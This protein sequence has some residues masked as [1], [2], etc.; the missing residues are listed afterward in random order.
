M[1]NDYSQTKFPQR[2]K[3]ESYKTYVKNL[4]KYM[5]YCK[6]KVEKLSK[7]IQKSYVFDA[8]VFEQLDEIIEDLFS[9]IKNNESLYLRNNNNVNNIYKDCLDIFMTAFY[10]YKTE[11]E[12]I[13][14]NVYNIK[15][16]FEQENKVNKICMEQYISIFS[17]FSTFKKYYDE[18]NKYN[19]LDKLFILNEMYNEMKQERK[20]YKDIKKKDEIKKVENVAINEG[21]EEQ[22][23]LGEFVNEIIDKNTEK[24]VISNEKINIDKLLKSDELIYKQFE[25]KAEEIRN[26]IENFE[27]TTRYAFEG[28]ERLVEVYCDNLIAV[29]SFYKCQYLKI[30]NGLGSR[31]DTKKINQN[32]IDKKKRE[33]DYIINKDVEAIKRNI[34]LKKSIM[35]KITALKEALLL[36]NEEQKK[37]LNIKEQERQGVLFDIKIDD[38]ETEKQVISNKKTYTQEEVD[39]MIKELNDKKEKEKEKT[40]EDLRRVYEDKIKSFYKDKDEE[41]VVKFKKLEQSIKSKE[42]ENEELKEKLKKQKELQE[43]FKNNNN[44]LRIQINKLTD[45]LCDKKTENE[46]LKNEHETIIKEID[47]RNKQNIFSM[48]AKNEKQ[49][50]EYKYKIKSL[51]DELE[52]KDKELGGQEIEIKEK[53]RIITELVKKNNDQHNDI[54]ELKEETVS[55]YNKNNKMFKKK[56]EEEAKQDIEIATLKTQLKE[57]REKNEKLN[58]QFKEKDEENIDLKIKLSDLKIK[59]REFKK[60]EKEKTN[61]EVKQLIDKLKKKEDIIKNQQKNID[62][63]KQLLETE[64][65]KNEILLNEIQELR[66]HLKEKDKIVQENERLNQLVKKCIDFNKKVVLK[67]KQLEEKI[68]IL[69]EKNKKFQDNEQKSEYKINESEEEKPEEYENEE[70]EVE[71]VEHEDNGIEE[72]EKSEQNKSEDSK[73][74]YDNKSN[75]SNFIYTTQKKNSNKEIREEHEEIE[76]SVEEDVSEDSNSKYNNYNENNHKSLNRQKSIRKFLNISRNNN[77]VVKNNN[78]F[79]K[80][81]SINNLLNSGIDYENEEDNKIVNFTSTK[82]KNNSNKIEDKNENNVN[83]NKVT[84]LFSNYGDESIN[85][86]NKE[87]LKEKI[88]INTKKRADYINNNLEQLKT[89]KHLKGQPYKQLLITKEYI[90]NK[91]NREKSQLQKEHKIIYDTSNKEKERLKNGYNDNKILPIKNN[92]YINNN[93]IEKHF[94]LKKDAK[95]LKIPSLFGY[96]ENNANKNIYNDTNV[97]TNNLKKDLGRK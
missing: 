8:E 45:E 22:K 9:N 54:I 17:T 96:N 16:V 86:N 32:I 34:F 39:R 93:K 69:E 91:N 89:N 12:K 79:V 36:M 5:K 28:N 63:I 13:T 33:I 44:K 41:A 80:K 97:G 76:Q 51:I 4:L 83:T 27:Y 75:H 23:E 40:K 37:F 64:K 47:I 49:E 30:K 87:N 26:S 57:I 85:K 78:F 52:R 18:F 88:V 11:N 65:N 50:L 53:K 90:T 56:T 6:E 25:K 14:Q 15:N 62:D 61:E 29:L 48:K 66:K 59:D 72:D 67:N 71:E 70:F 46:K 84:H 68:S 19:N 94:D 7:I 38:I 55:H 2:L 35:N 43:E 95:T 3:T 92:Y 82:Q 60:T 10:C 74:K 77:N 73:S 42:Q 21:K 24:Q 81:E 58:L 31:T 1:K 20:R